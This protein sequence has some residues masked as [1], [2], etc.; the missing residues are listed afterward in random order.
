MT[1]LFVGGEDSDFVGTNKVGEAIFGSVWDSAYSRGYVVNLS[2]TDFTQP[3]SGPFT[4]MSEAWLHWTGGPRTASGTT[5]G[6]LVAM[7]NAA[8]G[9]LVRLNTAWGSASATIAVNTGTGTYSTSPTFTIPGWPARQNYDLHVKI[10]GTSIT[11]DFYAEASLVYSYTTALTTTYLI[12]NFQ[13]GPGGGNSLSWCFG[14]SQV[15]FATEPTI[16]F[17]VFTRPPTSDGFYTGFAGTFADVDEVVLDDASIATNTAQR[18]SFN[19][20]TLTVPAGREVK[21]IVVGELLRNGEPTLTKTR[22]FLRSGG[23]DYESA[24]FT[25]PFGYTYFGKVWETDPATGVK[26]DTTKAQASVEFGVR[27]L[28]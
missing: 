4:P 25:V 12:D 10:T 24:D 18:E 15:V 14:H 8:L 19:R 16:D 23:V 26:W 27:A 5:L 11:V 20:A 21:A 9:Q 1:I 22:L 28:A 17:R 2:T 6:V 7:T 13:L 3:G